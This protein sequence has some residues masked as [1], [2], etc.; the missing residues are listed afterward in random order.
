MEKVT[1]G[2]FD[3]KLVPDETICECDDGPGEVEKPLGW[4]KNV[5][6]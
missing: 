5:S 4:A 2:V 6:F 3:V 1:T